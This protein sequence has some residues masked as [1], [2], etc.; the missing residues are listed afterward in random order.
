M[1]TCDKHGWSSFYYPCPTCS[2][3][4]VNTNST[5]VA[6]PIVAQ[7]TEDELWNEVKDILKESWVADSFINKLKSKFTIKRKQ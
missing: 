7:E 3:E 6:V 1:F 2:N 4:T 5:D